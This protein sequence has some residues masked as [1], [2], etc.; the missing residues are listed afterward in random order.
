[1]VSKARGIGLALALLLTVMAV[2]SRAAGRP[3]IAFENRSGEN[4][5]VRLV[6]PTG[7]LVTVADGS[8]RTVE[9]SGGAYRIYVR[10]GVEGKY[11]YTRGD[12]FTIYEGPDGVDQISITLHKV[13]GGNYG[14]SPSSEAEFNR[15]H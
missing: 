6:G 7:G 1:M 15:G 3:T 9:V 8:T 5:A 12:S 10:Y 2:P 4:A 14:T 13:V 11:R